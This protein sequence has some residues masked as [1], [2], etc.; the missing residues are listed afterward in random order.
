MVISGHI[1]IISSDSMPYTHIFQNQLTTLK[2][3]GRYRFFV[4]L[5]RIVGKAPFA[6][7]NSPDGTKKEVNVWCSNDYLGM[8]QHPEVVASMEEAVR[9]YGVGSG[10]TR[11]IS[12]TAHPHV[13]LEKTVAQLH[14]KEAGLVFTSG[15]CAN[16]AA[17]SSI[18]SFLPDCL[19]ISDEKNHASVIQGIRNS[20]AEKVVVD[21]NDMK[22]LEAVLK[23][24]GRDRPKLVIATSV[25]SMDGD[26]APLKEICALSRE[27]HALSYVDEVHAVGMYGSQ[28][29]GVLSAIGETADIIQ[30][31]FA[32]A[33]GVVGGYITGSAPLVDFIRSMASGFIFTT[34]LP[35]AIATAARASV[36]HLRIDQT[37]RA[38]FWNRVEKLKAELAKTDLPVVENDSHIVPIVV[39]EAAL[40]KEI[41]DRLL[42][43]HQ[44][45]VQPIN[46]PTVPRGEERL[47][48]TITPAHTDEH[49]MQ[50]VE[51]L[52]E[53]GCRRVQDEAA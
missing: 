39:G 10:G 43:E 11:N 17:I 36:E 14:H 48:L 41:C 31:N 26:I 8:T 49:I 42:L 9:Q 16:E 20:R 1:L 24:A 44:I 34:S 35:P 45:Y 40:C 5:E 21:H 23:A 19:I 25:Y 46:Y 6:L 52:Q 29:A 7:W 4:D 27:Y 53:V 22:H 15:Y 18:A 38:R 47:R 30:G 28:G 32:K 2:R 33:Y 3:E 50:L 13:L 37:V 51:A 12:G